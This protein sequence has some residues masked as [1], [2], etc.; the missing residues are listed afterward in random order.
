MHNKKGQRGFTLVELIIVLAIIGILAGAVLLNV[1]P[2][3]EKARRARAITDL[4]AIDSALEIYNADNG[5]Y[6]TTQQGIQALLDQPT[7]APEPDNWQGPYLKNR[8]TVPLD[9]WG[10]EYVYLSPGEESPDSYDLYSYGKDGR[11]GGDG[12]N[13]DVTLR[14]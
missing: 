13:A 8:S 9:P 5:N 7:S 11:P 12:Y 1:G 6:P 4:S 10:N 3:R 14:E 2:Q